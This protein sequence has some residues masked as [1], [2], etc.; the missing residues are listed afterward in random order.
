MPSANS[1]S[2]IKKLADKLVGDY[3][4]ILK[5]L[6]KHQDQIQ[7]SD[8]KRLNLVIEIL[9]T[10]SQ[11]QQV[12]TACILW[13]LFDLKLIEL[14]SVEQNWHSAISALVI[15]TIT[16]QQLSEINSD[17]TNK[18]KSHHEAYR[19]MLISLA[20]DIRVIFIKLSLQLEQL[21]TLD[22]QSQ[23][24]QLAVALQTKEIFSPLANRLGIWLLK[25]ELEDLSFRYLEPDSYQKLASKLSTTRAE[26]EQYVAQICQVLKKELSDHG[27]NAEV[28]GRSK[29]IYSIH[30]KMIEKNLIFEQLFDLRATRILTNTV[31][32]CYTALGIVHN[33]WTPVPNEF[34][35]YINNPK[36]N[37]YQSLHTAVRAVNSQIIEVQIRTK[38]MHDFAESGVAAHWRY[39][40]KSKYDHGFE[41]K[42]KWLRQLLSTQ[43]PDSINDQL[44]E[45]YIYVLSPQGEVVELP[46]GSTALDFAYSIHSDLGHRTRGAKA[47]NKIVPLTQALT[48]MQQIEIL[49]TKE[50]KPSKDWMDSKRGYL[51]TASARSK[52]K[53]W[54]R[55]QNYEDNIQ[56]GRTSL[57]KEAKRLHVEVD[58][59]KL[60]KRF[61]KASVND[62]LVAIGVG[63]ISIAQLIS[64]FEIKLKP[65]TKSI[66]NNKQV[67]G[68]SGD[69]YIEGVGGLLTAIANCCQPVPGDEII[70]FITQTRGVTVHR[71]DCLDLLR[72]NEIHPERIIE[73]NWSQQQLSNYS[74]SILVNA[75]ARETLLKDITLILDNEK[76]QLEGLNCETKPAENIKQIKM[77]IVVKNIAH[78]TSVL[79]KI[80]QIRNVFSV[81]RE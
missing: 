31:E 46:Q 11:D 57:N 71:Q 45:D 41:Y 16:L 33:L 30:K 52:V 68:S 21:R 3:S 26:R 78:L 28:S 64:A 27:I 42:I 59:P 48:T 47:N 8:F 6:E 32:E 62:L 14:E 55:K 40:E 79:N 50:I 63:D 15:N 67:S 25:W 69:I 18:K 35:D 7:L 74:V 54:F 17:F 20:K 13:F 36:P 73:L 43:E 58:Y 29:H 60:L 22:Q 65:K 39:K 44:A 61:K 24:I 38:E 51:R 70:G 9:L 49:T 19:K 10:V 75:Y 34:D 23:Q 37:N 2:E 66:I 53:S 12:I 5:L 4:E 1:F 80:E 81:N 76:A 56:I 72:L 77:T